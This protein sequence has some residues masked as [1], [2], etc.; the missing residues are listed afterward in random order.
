MLSTLV[1]G[2]VGG[3]LGALIVVAVPP[4]R[5]APNGGGPGDPL[6]LSRVN[7]AGPMTVLKSNGGFR[8]LAKSPKRPPL[9]VFTPDEVA[10][11]SVSSSALV[12]NLNADMVDGL[13]ASTLAQVHSPVV[14]PAVEFVPTVQDELGFSA[15]GYLLPVDRDS[16]GN[17]AGCWAAP[18]SLPDGVTVTKIV[19]N[20][21]DDT[22]TG[23]VN[24][25]ELWRK[26]LGATALGV[27]IGSTPS[28]TD[29]GPVLQKLTETTTNSAPEDTSQTT[30]NRKTP[31]QPNSQLTGDR[32]E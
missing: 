22:T 5:G 12:T 31:R 16:D 28:S 30:Q 11:L 14:V 4:A 13:D 1:V 18:V 27:R 25:M 3:M 15:F 20:V 10:P 9:M 21:S 7:Q 8:I 32:E 24:W 2:I 17:A 6:L 19:A 29:S 26:P 23:T